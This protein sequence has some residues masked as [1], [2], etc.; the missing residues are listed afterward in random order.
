MMKGLS[1]FSSMSLLDFRV[2]PITFARY[3][4]AALGRLVEPQRPNDRSTSEVMEIPASVYFPE[5]QYTSTASRSAEAK[6]ITSRILAMPLTSKT[7]KKP[8]PGQGTGRN[9]PATALTAT[10]R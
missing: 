3:Q 9:D 5:N 1:E 4:T 7:E 8:S 2:S 6:A 10:L